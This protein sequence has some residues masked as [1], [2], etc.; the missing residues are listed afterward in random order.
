MRGS[1][2]ASAA[3]NLIEELVKEK[4]D[5]TVKE[6][7]DTD[8]AKLEYPAN[9]QELRERWRK[10]IKFDLLREQLG[11]KPLTEAEA[12]QKVRNAIRA[13]SNA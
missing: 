9:E 5:F 11:T 6:Y 10:R 7:L 12:R 2:N 13:S 4:H 3:F 1:W 8:Y